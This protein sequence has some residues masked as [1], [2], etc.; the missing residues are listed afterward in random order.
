MI[1]RRVSE[2]A[3][4]SGSGTRYLADIRLLIRSIFRLQQPR[5]NPNGV[6]A[7]IGASA[8]HA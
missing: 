8:D 7:S 4:V 2:I 5:F 3:W 1:I 6:D